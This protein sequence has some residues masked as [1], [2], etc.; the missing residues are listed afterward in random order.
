MAGHLEHIEAG[1]AGGRLQI[2]TG[3]AAKLQDLQIGVDEH[4]GWR[5]LVDGDAVGF[6]LGA[7]LDKEWLRS[8]A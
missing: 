6:A 8:R 4:A 7:E 3:R 1:L 2:V 5:E